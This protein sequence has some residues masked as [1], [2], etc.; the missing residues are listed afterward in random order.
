LRSQTF[1]ANS[2]ARIAFEARDSTRSRLNPRYA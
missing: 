1:Y 2:A